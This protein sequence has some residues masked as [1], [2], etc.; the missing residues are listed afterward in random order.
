MIAHKAPKNVSLSTTASCDFR[1]AS[2][3]CC[4]NEGENSLLTIKQNLSLSPGMH[5]KKYAA[6]A[7]KL[8]FQKSNI[9]R[10]REKKARRKLLSQKKRIFKT[11]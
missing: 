5:T 4:K 7:D 8:R 10:S 9:S 2:A 1:V 6:R 11:K 3:I